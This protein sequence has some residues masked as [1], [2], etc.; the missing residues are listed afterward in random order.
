MVVVVEK[1]WGDGKETKK[2]LNEYSGNVRVDRKKRR[3]SS[4][5]EMKLSCGREK[6]KVLLVVM[7]G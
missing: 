4:R 3:S 1:G 2:W 5:G 7:T 6:G